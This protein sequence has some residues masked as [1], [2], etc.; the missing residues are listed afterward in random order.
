MRASDALPC[1]SA[2][3]RG[4]ATAARSAAAGALG[5]AALLLPLAA[6]AQGAAPAGSAASTSAPTGVSTEV[7][8]RGPGG[9]AVV[10]AQVT[11]TPARTAP[12]VIF[13]RG[14]VTGDDGRVQ[15][16]GL[17]AGRATLAVRRIGYQPMSS[18]VTLP[19]A[20]PGPVVVTLEAVPQQLAAVVV[21]ASRRGPYTGRMADFNRRRDLGFGRFFTA[22][23]ID[24]RR[25]INTSDLLRMVPGMAVQTRGFT[26][27]LRLR[28][29]GCD[30][31]VW[32]DGAPATAGYLDVDAFAPSTLA[33]I[34]VYS[35]PA[36]VPVELRSVGGQSGCGVIA[37]WSRVPDPQTRRPKRP[38]TAEMLARLVESATVFTADQVDRPARLDSTESLVLTYPDS[39]RRARA[40]G[41]ALVEFVVDT[42][43][44][45]EV[46]T[47]GV[48]A[49]THAQ[50]ADAARA[51]ARQARFLPAER[52]GRLVRQL[53]QL[54][55]RWEGK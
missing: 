23:D 38:V 39:L 54:P 52:A 22:A 42:T 55:L 37:L 49:A 33:G 2:R 12:G 15:L 10:G 30:P 44:R 40:G 16:P 13:A 51:T 14:G 43:G 53:A 24:Q 36:T 7:L 8:V 6:H 18:E 9:T 3:S 26:S 4:V 32:V 17:P 27:V 25:P 35:G 1:V 20:G 21:R 19:V 34:E 47:V 41:E 11:L 50:F 29:S 46:E 28:N 48:V 45:V 31:L 5:A